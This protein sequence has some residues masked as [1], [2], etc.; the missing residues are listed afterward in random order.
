MDVKLVATRQMILAKKNMI[1]PLMQAFSIQ[2][3]LFI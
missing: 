2:G 1:L 3:M